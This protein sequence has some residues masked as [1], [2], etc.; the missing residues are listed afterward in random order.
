MIYLLCGILFGIVILLLKLLWD[1][2]SK[3]KKYEDRFTPVFDAELA[4]SE[5]E[6][7]VVAQ[8]SELDA[9]EIKIEDL[10]RD[11]TAKKVL[12]DQLE[13]SLAAF[14]EEIQL[15]ELGFYKPHFDFDDPESYKKKLLQNKDFQKGFVSQ[16]RAIYGTT[17]WTMGGSAAQGRV[18]VNRA[19]RLT[20]RAF[21]KECDAA[22][23]NTRWNN[24]LRMEERIRKTYE[25]INKLNESIS[26]VIAPEYLGFKLDELRITHEYREKKQEAK[27]EQAEIKRQMREEAK[28]AKEIEQAARDEQNYQKMLEKAQAQVANATG[29]KLENLKA[30]IQMLNEE[31]AE[32]HTKTE[33]AK[34]MAQMTKRGHIYVISNIG[35]FGEG[36]YKIGMTRRLEPLD[37]VKELGDASVPFL[38]DIH[39]MIF[40][41]D[42][43]ALEAELHRR[44][45]KQRV[46]LVNLRKEY[47]NVSLGEI[48]KELHEL[49]PD[50]EMILTVEARE[51]RESQ[52][53]REQQRSK[54]A[55]LVGGIEL[56]V[57]L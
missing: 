30:K 52:S 43:P 2:R 11:Y 33:R 55:A 41:D 28:L 51:F 1:K 42:A 35:S 54:Q 56:P 38:F 20:A 37:R 18:F 40:S 46:N 8:K 24:V 45:S 16:K 26:V 36:I 27:E 12:H 50:S 7:A 57:S 15:T 17:E 6:Q 23:A 34:S 39:A 21:N 44:F 3:L 10:K 53:I 25:T 4:V 14:N 19:I 48:E 9:V 32:A 22:I 47:F 5:A 49:S 31:L 13:R 29:E